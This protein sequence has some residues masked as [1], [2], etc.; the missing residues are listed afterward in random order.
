ML[1]DFVN[2]LNS[3]DPCSLGLLEGG[4]HFTDILEGRHGANWRSQRLAMQQ[5][6]NDT[7]P[8]GAYHYRGPTL[9]STI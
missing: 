4:E 5:S 2:D 8:C 1:M 7:I 3:E 9:S 6:A